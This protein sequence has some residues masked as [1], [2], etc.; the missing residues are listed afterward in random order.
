MGEVSIEKN[1]ELNR[2]DAKERQEN[3]ERN[4][5]K[6]HN[7]STV[8]SDLAFSSAILASWRFN[9]PYYTTKIHRVFWMY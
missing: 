4:R 9:S 5:E 2:Q 1:E 7:K 6:N 8:D 3:A